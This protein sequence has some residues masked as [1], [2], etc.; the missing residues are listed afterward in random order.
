MTKPKKFSMSNADL[1][2]IG[3]DETQKSLGAMAKM[4]RDLAVVN[5]SNGT[6]RNLNLLVSQRRAIARDP[7]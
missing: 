6:T 7:K 2:N 3:L 1:V 4:R 5:A